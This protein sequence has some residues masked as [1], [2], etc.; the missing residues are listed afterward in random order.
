M[1]VAPAGNEAAAVG[2][3][4]TADGAT[5]MVCLEQPWDSASRLNLVLAGLVPH[6]LCFR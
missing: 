6:G 4:T 5:M 3:S 1:D 2:V